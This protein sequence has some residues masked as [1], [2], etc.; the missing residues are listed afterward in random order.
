[1]TDQ[2]TSRYYDL[3]LQIQEARQH[4]AALY[5]DI[6]GWE[7]EMLDLYREDIDHEWIA[8]QEESR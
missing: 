7:N 4:I 6:D 8:A 1:M 3:M 5:G 2:T